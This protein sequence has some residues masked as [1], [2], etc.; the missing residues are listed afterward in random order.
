MEN[1]VK[2]EILK[3]GLKSF[4]RGLAVLPVVLPLVFGACGG[5]D[6]NLVEPEPNPGN[7]GNNDYGYDGCGNKHYFAKSCDGGCFREFRNIRVALRSSARSDYELGNDHIVGVEDTVDSAA[8]VSWHS[9]GGDFHNPD[10]LGGLPWIVGENGRKVTYD[11]VIDGKR[12]SPCFSAK[13]NQ[14]AET[15]GHQQAA[16]YRAEIDAALAQR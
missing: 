13:D 8:M 6:G 12:K 16:S 9:S 7:G 2:I 14:L 1:M 4:G 5:G 15:A 11:V 3:E 10:S